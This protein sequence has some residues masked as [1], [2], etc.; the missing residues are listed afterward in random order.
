MITAQIAIQHGY[1]DGK[2]LS[3]ELTRDAVSSLLYELPIHG[4]AA[5]NM[6]AIPELNDALGEWM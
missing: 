3:C 1:G 2:E 4:Y 6:A 5:V